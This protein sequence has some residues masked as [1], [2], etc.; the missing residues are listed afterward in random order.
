MFSFRKCQEAVMRETTEASSIEFIGY[1][2]SRHEQDGCTTSFPGSLILP[3]P[4][5]S[6][7]RPWLGLVTC[8]LDNWEHQGGVLCNQQFVALSFVAGCDCHI[9]CGVYQYL[10]FRVKFRIIS[11]PTFTLRLSKSVLR[12]FSRRDFQ[13]CRPTH[14]IYGKSVIFQQWTSG[15][16]ISSHSNCCF[17]FECTRSNWCKKHK[18]ISRKTYSFPKVKLRQSLKKSWMKIKLIWYSCNALSLQTVLI[19]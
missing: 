1:R 2:I 3:P 9:T 12:Q 8:H 13:C 14:W 10:A 15:S 6:E 16:T 17:S 7:E 11:V 18:N 5:A 19:K 4:G